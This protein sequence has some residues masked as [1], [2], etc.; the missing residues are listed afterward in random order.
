[1]EKMKLIITLLMLALCCAAPA[2]SQWEAVSLGRRIMSLATNGKEVFA[3]TDGSGVLRSTDG[4]VSWNQASTGLPTLKVSALAVSGSLLYA[5]STDSG[6]FVYANEGT[7]WSKINQGLSEMYVQVLAAQDSLVLA[8]TAHG[9]FRSSDYGA[10]WK[11]VVLPSGYSSLITSILLDGTTYWAAG[12]HE[13]FFRSTDGGITWG[14]TTSPGT[15]W[16]LAVMGPRLI[17]GTYDGVRV[18]TDDGATWQSMNDGLTNVDIGSLVAKNGYLL[19]G[20]DHGGVYV[21]TDSAAHWM[22]LNTG[23]TDSSF[24]DM[25]VHGQTILAGSGERVW[26][27]TA[28]D[29][30]EPPGPPVLRT[31]ANHATAQ[32]TSLLLTWGKADLTG[33]FHVQV[34]IDSTF[35]N[36]V[37]VDSAVYSDTVI[38]ISNLQTAQR[39]FWRVAGWNGRAEG[40]YS[41]VWSFETIA[42]PP[43]SPI[44]VSPGQNGVVFGTTAVLAWH[45]AHSA[46][47]YHIQVSADSLFSSTLYDSTVVDTTEQMVVPLL[48]VWY[49]RVQAKNDFGS[50]AFSETRRFTARQPP[51]LQSLIDSAQAGSTVVAPNRLF[52]EV[53]TIRKPLTLISESGGTQ[54]R[55]GIRI[56]NTNTVLIKGITLLAADMFYGSFVEV[57]SVVNLRMDSVSLEGGLKISHSSNVQMDDLTAGYHSMGLTS[58]ATAVRV[59]SSQSITLRQGNIRGSRGILP[60][61]I[62]GGGGVFISGSHDV[63]LLSSIIQGGMGSAGGSCGQNTAGDGGTGL[64]A[65]SS[66]GIIVDSSEVDGGRGGTPGWCYYYGFGQPGSPGISMDATAGSHLTVANTQISYTYRTDSTSSISLVNSTV[67]SV[68]TGGSPDNPGEFSLVGNYPNPFNPSTTIRYGLPARS[69]VRL[70]VFNTL[71]QQ[72]A[73]LQDG[74]Q[75]SGYHEVRF[76]GSNLPSGV[77]FYRMESGTF[78]ET[79]KLVLTK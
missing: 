8:G 78:T 43:P 69:H 7:Y 50:S 11:K 2:E 58:T 35:M 65:E 54:I 60:L 52:Q 44:L 18:T 41:D 73:V 49:W 21:S 17:A 45:A 47:S 39:Y 23:L 9:L 56:I 26:R 63:R 4:G 62:T 33:F 24:Y 5:G 61:P 70:S 10:N 1:M 30:A 3:G 67:T 25:I 40:A 37:I 32:R 31:P 59:Q 28:M 46:L 38:H 22:S 14:A 34:G 53:V 74:E 27:R 76:D 72:V 13:S 75:E 57:D 77:Y 15:V 71:G 42:N 20:T 79:K 6:A 19:A 64:T 16:G 51:T 68:E 29:F 66:D 48:T 55:G 12:Y 36:G